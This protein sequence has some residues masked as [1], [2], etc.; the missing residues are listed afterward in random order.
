MFVKK[1]DVPNAREGW[2]ARTLVRLLSAVCLALLLGMPAGAG[3]VDKA[4]FLRGDVYI[5]V[6]RGIGYGIAIDVRD[7]DRVPDGVYDQLLVLQVNGLVPDEFPL[8]L[9]SASVS[10][11]K[12]HVLIADG[13][14]RQIVGVFLSGKLGP[15]KQREILAAW[16]SNPDAQG[17]IYT[18]FGLARYEADA[19]ESGSF[20]GAWRAPMGADWLTGE[21]GMSLA[22]ARDCHAGG[23]GATS[24]SHGCHQGCSITCGAGTYACCHCSNILGNAGFAICTCEPTDSGGIGGGDGAGGRCSDP[25]SCPAECAS[26]GGGGGGGIVY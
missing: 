5:D 13:T 16:P 17:W 18:G 26:C 4:D 19:R 8:H 23:P 2:G 12:E 24:C 3:T 20:G 15:A 11:H 25:L 14:G 7:G 22:E 21:A 1:S 6:M 9:D 10:V